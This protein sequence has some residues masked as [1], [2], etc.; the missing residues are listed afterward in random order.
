MITLLYHDV[1]SVN[2]DD[3]S[4]F[5]GPEAARY[6][7]TPEEFERHLD[8]VATKVTR[9]PVVTTSADEL[10]S[11]A[12]GSWLMTF[13]DGGVS[14]ITDIAEQLEHRGWRGWF[15]I[16]T[17][18]IGMPSFCTRAQLR[19]LHERGHVIGSHSCSHPER[20]SNCS[21]EQLLDEWQRSRAVLSE[22]I[23]QLVTTASVPGGFYSRSVARAAAA[24]GIEVLFNSEP[25]TSLFDVDGC[26]IVGRYNVYRGMPASDAA[27]LV[28]S[29]F[30]RWRQSAFW[31]AKKVAKTIAGPAYRTLRQRLLRRAYSVDG[32]VLNVSR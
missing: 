24:S 1:T 19:E 26:L 4:G 12:S 11:A 10:R 6:K 32:P 28:G 3:S 25:T 2:A 17:D 15:F 29:R 9:P 7:L 27:S 14:A 21:R 8:A 18:Y 30:R 23:G 16:A 20:I 22:I 5:A 13:D 31:N